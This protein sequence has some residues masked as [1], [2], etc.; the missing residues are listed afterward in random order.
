[1]MQTGGYDVVAEVNETLLNRFLKL[2]YCIGKFP[3]FSGT[4]TL[5]IE[6]IP[7]SLQVTGLSQL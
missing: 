3:I 4:Y 6:D 7:A 2:A 1:M 5:P